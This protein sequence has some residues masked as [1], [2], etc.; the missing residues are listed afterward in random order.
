MTLSPVQGGFLFSADRAIREEWSD[1]RETQQASN[2]SGLAARRAVT[3]SAGRA[4]RQDVPRQAI[5][6]IEEQRGAVAGAMQ[7]AQFCRRIINGRGGEN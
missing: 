4:S 6:V 1:G 7:G 5:G 3:K 2:F